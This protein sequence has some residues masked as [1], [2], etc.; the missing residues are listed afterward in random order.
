MRHSLY[1]THGYNVL[2]RMA[3]VMF[4]THPNSDE[5]IFHRVYKGANTRTPHT[6]CQL[7]LWGGRHSHNGGRGLTHSVRCMRHVNTAAWT[8]INDDFVNKNN[9]L[10]NKRKQE[11]TNKTSQWLSVR[12]KQSTSCRITCMPRRAIHLHCR[13]HTNA[14]KQRISR[15]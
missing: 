4:G 2:Y 10:W 1:Q 14:H 11:K 8:E 7:S 12:C 5:Y 3:Y 9:A 13:T 6:D 15:L